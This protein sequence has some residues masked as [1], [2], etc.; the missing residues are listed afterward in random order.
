MEREPCP[1]IY[2]RER[3]AFIRENHRVGVANVEK[4]GAM[5]SAHRCSFVFWWLTK[6]G[7]EARCGTCLARFARETFG[8]AQLPL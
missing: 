8:V 3:G 7:Y 1:F 4:E 2:Q 5:L 6:R